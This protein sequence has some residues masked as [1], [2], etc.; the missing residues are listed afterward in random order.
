[1]VVKKQSF[2]ARTTERMRKDE[3]LVREFCKTDTNLNE[4][5]YDTLLAVFPHLYNLVDAYVT[6]IFIIYFFCAKA[7]PDCPP[8]HHTKAMWI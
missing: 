4:S 1:M 5:A 6:F 8:S 3:Q 2:E 7:D